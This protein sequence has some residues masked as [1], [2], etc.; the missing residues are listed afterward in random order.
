MTVDSFHSTHNADETVI[1]H[2]ARVCVWCVMNDS[3]HTNGASVYRESP[4]CIVVIKEATPHAFIN[5][6][7]TNKENGNSK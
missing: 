2:F 7:P 4:P 5:V 3:A 1:V 6:T